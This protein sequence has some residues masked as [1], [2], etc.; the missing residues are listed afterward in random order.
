[1]AEDAGIDAPI[2]AVTVF[3]DGAGSSAAAWRGWRQD[4]GRS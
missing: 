4:W 1:M 3:R 2:V